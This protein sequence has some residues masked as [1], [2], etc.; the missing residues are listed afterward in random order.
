MVK[1]EVVLKEYFVDCKVSSVSFMPHE[2]D[3]AGK[4]FCYSSYGS[5][6]NFVHL[7]KIG[8][9][10]LSEICK[11]PFNFDIRRIKFF[12]S[13]TLVVADDSGFLSVLKFKSDFQLSHQFNTTDNRS[14][15]FI[16]DFDIHEQ[17]LVVTASSGGKLN[18]I[19][20]KRGN[21]VKQHTAKS[22][23]K[24]PLDENNILIG[25]SDGS[26]Q[27]WDL[28]NET[29]P[30]SKLDLHSADGFLTLSS[31]VNQILFHPRE[32]N[33]VFTCSSD[34]SLKK[35]DPG[36]SISSMSFLHT[37]IKDDCKK[38]ENRWSKISAFEHEITIS[39]LVGRNYL[40]LNEMAFSENSLISGT[41]ARYLIYFND[42]T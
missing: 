41:D 11:Y 16:N 20:I 12:D 25:Y 40:S 6:K 33:L 30:I 4:Y 15:F 9:A 29:Y 1:K 22:V 10:N 27:T 39:N 18:L 37:D 3:S 26:L 2:V 19:D 32:K 8:D 21:I 14:N 38:W 13:D 42:V 35:L 28:R 23:V 31:L 36:S 17:G 34:S 5:E 7:K 24:N